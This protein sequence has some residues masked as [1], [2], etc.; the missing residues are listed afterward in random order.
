MAVIHVGCTYTQRLVERSR[1]RFRRK[2]ENER[3]SFEV[4][5]RAKGYAGVLGVS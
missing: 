4:R 1:K 2:C 3:A 5:L